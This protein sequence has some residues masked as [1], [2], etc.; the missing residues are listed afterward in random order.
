[1]KVLHIALTDGGGAGMG[2]MGVHR[3]LLAQGIDSRVLVAQKRSND[4]RV[5][6]M[7]PNLHL[8]STNKVMRK[9]QRAAC[10]LGLCFNDYDLWHHRICSV[11]RRYPAFFTQP[12]SQYDVL[13]HPLVQK[14]DIL[15]LHFI[16]GLVDYPSF[17]KNVRQPVVWTVRDENPGLGGFHFEETK[18]R[19]YVPY[20]SLEEAFVK[21]KRKAIESCH[22]LHLV[23]LS[24]VVKAFCQRIDYLAARP[25]TIIPNTIDPVCFQPFQQEEAKQKLG[26]P[27]DAIVLSFVS[28]DLSEER[29]GLQLVIDAIKALNN[30]RIHLLCVGK[31]TPS[32]AATANLHFLGAVSNPTFL[33]TVYSASDFYINASSQETFGKTMVEALYCGTP[34]ITTPVG[35]APEII[36]PHNGCLFQRSTA[37][38]TQ[39]INKALN[40]SFHSPAAIRHEAIRLFD[41]ER[42]AQQHI[43]LYQSLLTN[44]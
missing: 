19:F 17:F 30:Q 32:V 3:A 6:E 29:K 13:A 41:A 42:I 39:A 44:L 11:R 10:R 20:A 38:L 23:S 25:N 2:M 7:Q 43:R 40:R 35:I 33:S 28:Y 36:K 4:E 37:A 9:L 1:M 15:H 18:Q 26:L 34:V 27:A 8:W 12:F 5:V 24:N 31:P 14:A 16:A 22:T 21:I